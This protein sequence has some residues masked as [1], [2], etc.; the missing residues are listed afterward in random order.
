MQPETS[1]NGCYDTSS[2]PSV[3]VDFR[4]WTEAGDNDSSLS[5]L[6][7]LGDSVRDTNLSSVPILEGLWCKV[8]FG[9][10]FLLGLEGL[11]VCCGVDC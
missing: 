3:L 5:F 1:N 10:N 9:F 8:D 11:G 2:A 4:F 7:V 6:L